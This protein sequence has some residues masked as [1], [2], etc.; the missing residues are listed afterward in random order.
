[1]K[2]L[3]SLLMVLSVITFYS[4]S[5]DDDEGGSDVNLSYPVTMTF[6]GPSDKTEVY[7]FQKS[8]TDVTTLTVTDEVIQSVDAWGFIEEV[9]TEGQ[10]STIVFDSA[11]SFTGTDD[12]GPVTGT[13]EMDGNEATM[14]YS[15]QGLSLT[16]TATTDD[17][18]ATWSFPSQ[19]VMQESADAS[20][21]TQG[22][23]NLFNPCG[24]SPEGYANANLE[25]GGRLLM[26]RYNTIYVA[27]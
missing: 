8:G 2:K 24:D 11:T 12:A 4:C 23:C 16:F 10:F 9:D 17:D 13:L 22:F 15:I 6:D 5:D 7:G 20:V 18:G 21:G 3:L 14:T 25:D 27:Q 19:V 1:M 26:M